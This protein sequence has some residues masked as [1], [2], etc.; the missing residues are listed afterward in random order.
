[1]QF[2]S[3]PPQDP[4]VNPVREHVP[5]TGGKIVVDK[6]HIAKQ[7]RDAVDQVWRSENKVPVR[8]ATTALPAPN[9]TG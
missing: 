8:L 2:A 6:L 7:L 5:D 1:M 3:G 9:M 4:Y